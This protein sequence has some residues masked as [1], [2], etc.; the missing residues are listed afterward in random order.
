MEQENQVHQASL[1]N[2]VALMLA[3]APDREVLAF[4][5]ELQYFTM[6]RRWHRAVVFTQ[7]HKD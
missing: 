4:H 2:T 6:P 1:S 3:W 7:T 5:R